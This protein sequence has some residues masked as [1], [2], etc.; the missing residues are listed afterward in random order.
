MIKNTRLMII[1][2][3]IIWI[4]TGTISLITKD[5]TYIF[6]SFLI[7]IFYFSNEQ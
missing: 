1:L 5:A 6:L 7:T 4:V 2:L 3:A